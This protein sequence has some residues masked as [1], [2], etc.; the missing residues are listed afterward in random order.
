MV[1][2]RK[3][4]RK[5]GEKIFR[6]GLDYFREGRILS[7]VK[8]GDE[9]IGTVSGTRNYRTEVG[10]KALTCEC[11]CPYQGR[12]KHGAALL[13]SYLE[14]EYEDGDK[15]VERIRQ[16]SGEDLRN[17]VEK[18]VRSNPVLLSDFGTYLPVEDEEVKD[19][20]IESWIRKIEE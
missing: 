13:L 11:S 4:K 9:L 3:I 20:E 2:E 12:C 1:T 19:E 5:F 18:T 8:M 15:F 16:T 17:F 7:V 14:G 10:L 6:R